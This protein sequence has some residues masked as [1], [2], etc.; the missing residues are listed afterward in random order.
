M[1]NPE[2]K[3]RAPQVNQVY[4]PVLPKTN[5]KLTTKKSKSFYLDDK[6]KATTVYLTTS[7]KPPPIIPSCLKITN[8]ETLDKSDKWLKKNGLKALKLNLDR[9]ER[10]I[11]PGSKVYR[12]VL[13]TV[14]ARH[15]E[16]NG[17]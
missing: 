8:T 2:Q 11:T 15:C 6:E 5:V 16:L 14:R 17:E 12:G 3:A 13:P 4:P 10:R 1:P 7:V 9:W